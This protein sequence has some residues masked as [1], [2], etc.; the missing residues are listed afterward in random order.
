MRA[1]EEET[2]LSA[3]DVSQFDVVHDDEAVE[4]G[5]QGGELGGGCLDEEGVGFGEDVGVALNAA[6]D[7]EDE[8]VAAVA[9][10]EV[11]DGV[12]HHA[13]EP[14]DAVLACYA[15][16]ARVIEGG[17]ASPFEEG[18]ELG[19]RWGDGFGMGGG[20]H[21]GRHGKLCVHLIIAVDCEVEF[22]ARSLR[23]G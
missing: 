12:G 10:F 9:G 23:V 11:L 19:C 2:G 18:G 3:A 14:A 8:V 7:A 1:G 5:H 21:S 20:G 22:A 17:D 13:V 6:L 16:P 15:N 4:E